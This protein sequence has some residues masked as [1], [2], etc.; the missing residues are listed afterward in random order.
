MTIINKHY[1]FTKVY[2][3]LYNKVTNG[4]KLFLIISEGISQAID[5]EISRIN[6]ELMIRAFKKLKSSKKDSIFDTM[7]DGNINGPPELVTTLQT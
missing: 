3:Y 1:H 5:N 6:R 7:S 4:E 2:E